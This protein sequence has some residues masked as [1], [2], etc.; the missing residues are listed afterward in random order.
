MFTYKQKLKKAVNSLINNTICDKNLRASLGKFLIINTE[1]KEMKSELTYFKN[2][3]SWKILINYL[4]NK[5]YNDFTWFFLC[6]TMHKNFDEYIDLKKKKCINSCIKRLLE[7][8]YIYLLNTEY[9]SEKNTSVLM[10]YKDLIKPGFSNKI[11]P[12][13]KVASNFDNMI[14][15]QIQTQYPLASKPRSIFQYTYTSRRRH[16]KIVINNLNFN[17]ENTFLFNILKYFINSFNEDECVTIIPYKLFYYYFE[18][19]F[20]E[21]NLPKTIKD[22]NIKTFD[23]QFKFYKYQE[24]LI[25]Y[26]SK[27]PLYTILV[28]FYRFLIKYIKKENINH[29]IFKNSWINENI[30]YNNYFCQKYYEGYTYIY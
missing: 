13:I 15:T 25:G 2:K 4:K 17:T 30:L 10:E 21:N 7:E 6:D 20:R 5:K 14:R 24:N 28:D 8:F 12:R 19:S 18:K 9:I 27:R 23:I 3:N 1:Q 16:T 11:Y 22:F 29:D 26:N